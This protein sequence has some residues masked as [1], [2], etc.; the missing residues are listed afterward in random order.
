M[1]IPYLIYK[2]LAKNYGIPLTKTN[3]NGAV[4][5]KSKKELSNDIFIYEKKNPGAFIIKRV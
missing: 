5:Y 3:D 1:N 4:I 2:T